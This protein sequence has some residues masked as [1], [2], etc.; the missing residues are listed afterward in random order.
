M[1]L[2]EGPQQPLQQLHVRSLGS[3]AAQAR[4]VWQDSMLEHAIGT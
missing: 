1:S 4:Q 3:K 2:R